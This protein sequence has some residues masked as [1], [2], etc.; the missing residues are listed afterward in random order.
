MRLHNAGRTPQQIAE[1]MRI[2]MDTVYARLKRWNLPTTLA[3]WT[4]EQVEEVKAKW[5]THSASQISALTGISRD[6]II[7]KMNRL[8]IHKGKP[9]KKFERCWPHPVLNPIARH[10]DE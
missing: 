6:G 7:A 9:K 1:E 4:P 3:R 10:T 2:S 5:P 8:G